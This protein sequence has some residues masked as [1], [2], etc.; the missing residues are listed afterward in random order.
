M[1]GTKLASLN[2]TSLPKHLDELRVLLAANPIDVLAINETRVDSSIKDNELYIPGYE[3]ARRD[4]S[5]NGRSGGGVC[6]YIRSSINYSVRLDL[7]LDQ[8]ENLCIEIRKPRSK[9]FLV[10]TWYRP[11]GST[12]DKFNYF[13]TLVGRLDAEGA[14]FY[15]M[16]DLNCNLSASQL[17]HNSCLLTNI[18]NLYGLKQLI[19][20]P[21]RVSESSSTLIDLIF[22]NS[23]DRVV[24]SGVSHVGISDHSL[25][26]VFRKLSIGLHNKGHSTVTYRKF[27]QFNSMNFRSDICSQN[28]DS[29][30]TCNDPNDMWLAWKNIFLSV[31]DK[32]AP[33][34]IKRVRAFKS[35]WITPLLKQRMH[36]RDVLKLKAIRSNDSIDWSVYKKCRNSVNI[37]IG[38]AKE[39]YYKN[40][41]HEN[42]GNPRMTWSII[43]ELT[44]RKSNNSH[45]KEIK[46]NGTS[47]VNA[48]ELSDAFNEHFASVGPK[49]AKDIPNGDRSHLDYLDTSGLRSNNVNFELNQTNSS[50]VSSILSKLCKSK[51]TGLDKIS[52]RLLRECADLIADSLCLIFNRSIT[53]GIFPDEWKCSKVIPLFKQ[54][55]RFDLNNYRPISI[56]PVVAKVFE[57]VVYDQVFTYLTENN[58]ISN[59]QSGFRC[60]H[61]T[62]TALLEATDNWAFSID[63]GEVNAVVFLDL[64]KAFDT[65]DHDIL[66]SKLT[67]Y[68]ITGNSNSWFKSYLYGRN[69]KCFVNGYLSHNRSL[70]C[71]IPQGTI[72]GPLLFLLYINDLPNCLSHS[73][74]R[75]YADDTHL[76]FSSNNINSIN[77]HLNQDLSS[78]NE[79]LIANKLTLNKSKTEFML[80]GS[81]QRLRTLDNAPSLVI[82]EVPVK[83]VFSTKSL[84]V[85]IDENLSWNVH[86]DKLCKKIASGIGAL[87]RIRPFVPHSTLQSIFNSL[88]QPHFDYCS[89][90]WGTCNKTLANR[91]QKLQN[92]AARVLTFSSYDTNADGLLKKLGWK[93]LESQRQV[94]K[95]IMVYKSL[96]GLAPE[97]LRSKFVDRCSMLN[98][99]LRDT[100][101]KI[102]VP[103]PRTNFRKNSFSYNGA[104]LWNS[105]PVEL[106][107]AQT[108]SKFR[109]G[110]SN[111]FT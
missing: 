31:V 4:R 46:N 36:E 72:L 2:I 85:H 24:C 86:I 98:Y 59:H 110:C 37:E 18:T 20:E 65:V 54:G 73:E 95:A 109:V 40:A 9:P 39:L 6:F 94:H 92:R 29:I 91:L 104:V 38:Q 77:Y 13:E 7:S 108:L 62:V 74:P 103:L 97:Y 69:Q 25:I 3:I 32:H 19:S 28:W 15:V 64:K 82:D 102:A 105:L 83:Q 33:L 41:F 45:I 10:V 8:L 17:D 81:R 52:A 5:T 50:I 78:V 12:V 55:E 27:K 16:G 48:Q 89:A 47:I 87:K 42:V 60:L 61:S 101:G 49:L 100:A 111:L 79:W 71:G 107:Q 99:S 80:I 67:E 63:R 53:T 51:A 30:N 70:S 90:V 22:T 96:N 44:A 23:P 11:P 84:G 58:I 66:L 93:N 68:G 76:T 1:R 57:R 43:N 14:E 88:I 26:Y 34:R 35:P 75:M 56:I 21:T 106:R